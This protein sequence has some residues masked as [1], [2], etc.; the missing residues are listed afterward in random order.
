MSFWIALCLTQSCKLFHS[1]SL[2]PH[3]IMYIFS[4]PIFFHI[5]LHHHTCSPTGS[6]INYTWFRFYR[7]LVILLL[8]FRIFHS[9]PFTF[10]LKYCHSPLNPPITLLHLTCLSKP[11]LALKPSSS[12]HFNHPEC[13][14]ISSTRH[15]QITIKNAPV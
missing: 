4:F 14:R 15:L 9:F 7:R 3:N 1:V 8:L 13:L 12:I 10:A 5:K 6:F 2:Y 11:S